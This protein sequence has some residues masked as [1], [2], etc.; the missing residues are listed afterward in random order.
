MWHLNSSLRGLLNLMRLAF[1]VM[2]EVI[3]PLVTGETISLLDVWDWEPLKLNL[4]EF[5]KGFQGYRG[6]ELLTISGVLFWRKTCL[7]VFLLV[8]ICDNM[9]G[10][11]KVQLWK[12]ML[13]AVGSSGQEVVM[14]KN[15]SQRLPGRCWLEAPLGVFNRE[16]GLGIIYLKFFFLRRWLFV[17]YKHSLVNHHDVRKKRNTIGFIMLLLRTSQFPSKSAF[18]CDSAFLLIAL[19]IYLLPTWELS[20]S[21]NP[22]LSSYPPSN[23]LTILQDSFTEKVAPNPFLR[24]SHGFVIHLQDLYVYWRK[25]LSCFNQGKG[26]N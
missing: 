1:R 17:L 14:A 11:W 23:I 18:P 2:L 5:K 22:P 19:V 24:E 3:R 20:L 21:W 26:R 8:R 7:E 25:I 12:F 6:Q 15:S 13:T 4:L 10:H 9:G 16:L